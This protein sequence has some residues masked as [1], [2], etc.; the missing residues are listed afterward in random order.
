[1]YAFL[2]FCCIFLVSGSYFQY[3]CA[4]M[5]PLLFYRLIDCFEL[6]RTLESWGGGGGGYVVFYIL[7]IGVVYSCLSSYH[8]VL[9][10]PFY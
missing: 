2:V 7:Q 5:L 3:D 10:I 9:Y 8:A 4:S 6:Y 1:M